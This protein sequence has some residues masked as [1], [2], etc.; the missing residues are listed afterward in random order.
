[1]PMVSVLTPTRSSTQHRHGLLYESYTHQTYPL[2][3]LIVMDD[4]PTPSPFFS[5]LS[6]ETVRYIH[7]KE[8]TALGAKR[9]SLASAAAGTVLA[10][11]DDDDYYSPAYLDTMVSTLT[12]LRA[13]LTLQIDHPHH[14]RYPQSQS[15]ISET[16]STSSPILVA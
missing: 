8:P 3:E 11:F 4:S 6:D 1:M 16:K 10:H 13:T 12:A 9:N 5:S 14:P 15:S 7:V 2:K